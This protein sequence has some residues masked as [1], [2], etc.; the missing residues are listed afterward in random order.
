MIQKIVETGLAHSVVSALRSA[1]IRQHAFYEPAIE[2]RRKARVFV[3][4]LV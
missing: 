1:P 4:E 3:P 2:A